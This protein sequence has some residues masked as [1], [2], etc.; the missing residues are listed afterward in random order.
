MIPSEQLPAEDTPAEGSRLA[1]VRR[2]GRVT[3]LVHWA[4]AATMFCCLGTGAV[5]LLPPLAE[6]VGRRQLVESIHLYA[7]LAL[8]VPMLVAAAAGSYRRDLRSLNRFTVTDGT[9]LR[10]NLRLG[11]W[12]RAQAGAETGAASRIGK[13]NAGQKLYAAFIAGAILVMLGTG[14]LMRWGAGLPGGLPLAW[15]TGATFVHDLLTYGLAFGVAGHLWMA[16][17]DPVARVGIITG[18]VPAWWATREHPAWK[19]SPRPPD[20]R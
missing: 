4:T 17:R 3:R 2:F 6:L 1:T 19:A 13:F 7:G 14:T 11:T 5:L 10:A 18:T 15:R 12:R 16:A 9:W 8:P 20:R